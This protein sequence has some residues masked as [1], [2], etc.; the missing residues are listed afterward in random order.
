M[1][2][3]FISREHHAEVVAAKDALIRSLEAQN[4]VLAERLAEPIAVT[5]KLPEDFAMLQPAV[6]RRKR[7]QDPSQANS[8]KE[9]KEVDWANVD[10]GNPFLMAEL[11]SQEFGRMLSPVELADWMKRVSR[12]VAL[13]KQQGIRTPEIP[14]VGT[15]ETKPVPDHIL[16]QIAEAERV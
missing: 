5:V 6:V 16:E 14:S 7:P 15:L 1:R 13:A 4:A 8:R 12:Q 3:P 10:L 2:F 9:A 11:A